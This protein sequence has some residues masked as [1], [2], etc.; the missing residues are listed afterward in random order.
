MQVPQIRVET[1]RGQIEIKTYNAILEIEQPNNE[2]SI[3]QPPAL[4]EMKRTPSKLSINQT[5]AREDVDLKSISRRIEEA[6]DQ[7]YRD[8]LSGIE[9]LSQ[10]GDELMM[11]ER[12]GNA[13]PEQAKRN[14][15][16]PVFE[17]NI[18]W[19]PSAGSVKIDYSPGR[20]VINWRVRKPIINSQY[21]SIESTYK[22]GNVEIN[23]KSYP[24]IKIDFKNLKYSGL[25][26]E[27]S[28]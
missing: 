4:L 5:K 14:S 20:L 19:V 3:E 10:D 18:G 1:V 28:I 26:F 9:R 25:N 24:S 6:A 11:I 22:P 23:M 8:V 15:E 12:G 27:Q 7:G 2:L 13:I 17:F 16:S 21:K